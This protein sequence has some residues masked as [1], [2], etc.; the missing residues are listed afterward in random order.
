MSDAHQE[1]WMADADE[2]ATVRL[3]RLAGARPVAPA[4]RTARVRAAVHASWHAAGRRRALLRRVLYGTVSLAAAAMLLTVWRF[5][6]TDRRV[7]SGDVVAV[8]EQLDGMPQ[9]TTVTQGGEARARIARQDSI[10]AGDWIE[11]DARARVAF[12]FA[13]G[14]SVRLDVGS[15]ARALSSKAIELAAG[16]AYVDTGGE[17]GRFEVSTDMGIA[18]DIGTQFELRLLDRSLRLRVRTGVVELRDGARSVSGRAGTEITFT[19]NTAVSRPMAAHGPDW[20]WTAQVSPPLDIEGMALSIFLERVAREHGWRLHY[21]D[22]A[23]EREA[24]GIILHGSIEGLRPLEAIDVAI[25][26]SSLHHR[27]EAGTLVVLRGS[28]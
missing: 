11:T 2:E 15:R 17:S 10:R 1:H 12:R 14:T 18:R 9:R 8:V 21:S 4:H 24:S 6:Q 20:E 22:P 3:L 26:T 16:A 19:G 13:D 25:A 7:P 27:L 23:L 28:S 5:N